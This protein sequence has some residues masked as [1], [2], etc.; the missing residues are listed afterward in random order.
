MESSD[1]LRSRFDSTITPP[2]VDVEAQ[3][4][5]PSHSSIRRAAKSVEDRDK[6]ASPEAKNSRDFEMICLMQSSG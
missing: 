2:S 1:R 5:G 3:A 6:G 4:S